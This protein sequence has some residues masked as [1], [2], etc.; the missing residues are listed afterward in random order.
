MG[1]KTR[2]HYYSAKGDIE[3][4]IY[5]Y[6]G[7]IDNRLPWS[8]TGLVSRK[9]VISYPTNFS[10]MSKKDIE[11]LSDRGEMLTRLLISHYMP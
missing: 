1:A 9:S 10:S 5:S 6:L 11:Q 2:L 7:Q 8:P 3:G 4:F